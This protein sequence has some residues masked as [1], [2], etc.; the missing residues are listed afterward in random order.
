MTDYHLDT[1]Q[2]A[3][4]ADD[5]NPLE[6]RHVFVIGVGGGGCN[7]LQ[8][9]INKRINGVKFIAINTDTQSLSKSTADIRVQIGVNQTG[10]LG[11]GCDPNKGLM[12]AQE[13]LA[14]IK[15]IL[16][17]ADMVFITAGM[18]GGTGTGATPLIAKVAHDLGILTVGVVTR[19]FKFEGK[20]HISNANA[21]IAELS[22]HIDS[23]LVIDNDKLLRN[24]GSGVSLREAFSACDDVLYHAVLG[25]T[26]F[27]VN[28]GFIN[29]DFTD[30]L[31]VMRG[32]GFAMIGTGHG[33]G[34]NCIEDAIESAVCSP[35]IDPIVLASAAGLL[36]NFRVSPA[37]PM[38]LLDET[39]NALQRY[40]N[41]EADFK[42]GMIYDENL[43]PDEM[44][45]T[46]LITGISQQADVSQVA[47]KREIKEEESAKS[48]MQNIY[49]QASLAPR[50]APRPQSN[51][52]GMPFNGQASFTGNAQPNSQLN[53]FQRLQA[54]QA[55]FGALD[56]KD[57]FVITPNIKQ[58]LEKAELEKHKQ[59]NVSTSSAFVS[60]NANNQFANTAPNRNFAPNVPNQYPYGQNPNYQQ[61]RSNP[62]DLGAR[63]MYQNP[64][65]MSQS[66]HQEMRAYGNQMPNQ[67]PYA[68]GNAAY[69]NQASYGY[70]TRAQ[71][72]AQDPYAQ[73]NNGM[74][75]NNPNAYNPNLPNAQMQP[76]PQENKANSQSKQDDLE[77]PPILNRRIR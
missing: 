38:N 18:G 37:F 19:P 56:K 70:D 34:S 39:G 74:M 53:S 75:A 58:G 8:H 46:V 67:N 62:A 35:L 63:Q 6:T 47:P 52:N 29:V 9:A 1:A 16:K 43:E 41:S 72:Y 14:D 17:G 15:A 57:D 76:K 31:N 51:F 30:V 23:L 59:N 36:A 40:A 42:F 44:Y 33:K 64:E 20:R 71:G 24:L 61:L 12:A 73:G 54:M 3:D 60:S 68:P 69:A 11:A 5:I 4:S 2:I 21:G 25:I 22:K 77:L 26:D 7:A 66:Y 45:L 48:Q 49:S 13:S 65:A 32:R 10:G 27:I 50:Q 55:N 28:P